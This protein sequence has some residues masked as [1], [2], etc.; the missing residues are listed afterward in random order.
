MTAAKWTTLAVFLVILALI[1][2]N[3]FYR[4]VQSPIWQEERT[5]EAQALETG[6]LKKAADSHKF[7]WDETVWIV[8]GTDSDGDDAYVWLNKGGPV[9][10][11]AKDGLTK[12]GMKEHFLKLKPDAKLR[13]M[14]I[15][16]VGGVPVWEIFYSRKQSSGV[17]NY[18]DFYKFQDGAFIVTYKLP[19]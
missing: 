2:L 15:G 3:A 5:A 9:K 6:L 8:E 19:S 11:K 16:M 18:Y 4:S 7:V 17:L 13:H 1:G 12:A 14:E 10:L